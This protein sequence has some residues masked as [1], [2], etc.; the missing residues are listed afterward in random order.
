MLCFPPVKPVQNVLLPAVL[1]TLY[2]NET[3][4]F[5]VIFCTGSLYQNHFI[6]ND[7]VFCI[8]LTIAG[9]TLIMLVNSFVFTVK[10]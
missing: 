3:F 2:N 6:I 1:V 7:F 10:L 4:L 9:A 5:L 8:H